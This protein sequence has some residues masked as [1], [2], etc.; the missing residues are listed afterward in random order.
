MTVYYQ[1][2]HPLFSKPLECDQY[3]V[4][5]EGSERIAQNMVKKEIANKYRKIRDV[6]IKTSTRKIK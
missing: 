3:T 1:V 6:I 5:G 2:T 4:K